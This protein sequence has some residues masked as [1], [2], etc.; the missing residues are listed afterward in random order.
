[1]RRV[2]GVEY[3]I[4]RLMMIVN[5]WW[6]GIFAYKS[7]WK[8]AKVMQELLERHRRLLGKSKLVRAIRIDRRY[9]WD[10]FNPG[11]PSRSFNSFFK[12][13]LHEVVP[14]SNED[15]SLRR[16]LI[17]ITKKCPLNCEHCS[18]GA[19]LNNSDV[20]S[21]DE[22]KSKIQELVG[23]G[24]GQLVYSGG[25]PLTRFNDLL[26]LLQT[27]HN[28]C[29]QWIYTS[30]YGLTLEKAIQLKAAGLNGA[31]ISLDHHDEQKHNFFRR[32][33]K[34]YGWVME[35]VKNCKLAGILPS[36]NLCPTRDYIDSNGLEDYMNF[37]KTLDIPVVTILEPRSVGNYAGQDVELTASHRQRIQEL[38]NR[39]NFTR[40][41]ADYPTIV[42]PG[43]FRNQWPCGGGRSYLF[44][45][46]DGKLYPCPFCKAPVNDVSLTTTACLAS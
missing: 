35:A 42:Y 20:L 6:I 38:N 46:Y 32:N 9:Y 29:D 41:L 40:S 30:G 15:T 7:P 23:R 5:I 22:L 18:E 26:R 2:T 37:A 27:F 21:Y 3:S 44:L 31:A 28:D 19:T 12:N 8:A 1:M 34:S 14:I 39:F 13:Q 45:D 25:E 16:I 10:I 24:V 33:G 4:V 17:A 43:G 36:L 11:W